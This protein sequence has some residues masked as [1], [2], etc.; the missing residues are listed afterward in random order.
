[1]YVHTFLADRKKLSQYILYIY[2]LQ[3]S[4]KSRGLSEL[5]RAGP[6]L[7]VQ[8]LPLFD[9]ASISCRSLQKV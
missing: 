4:L 1:M 2:N 8:K 7:S 6:Q 5:C 9:F 3:E